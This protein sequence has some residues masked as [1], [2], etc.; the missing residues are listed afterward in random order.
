MRFTF[1]P[2]TAKIPDDNR[3]KMIYNLLNQLCQRYPGNELFSLDEKGYLII[4]NAEND[5]LCRQISA[6]MKQYANQTVYFGISPRLK[7]YSV[8]K[9]GLKQA[10]D[11]LN[12][13]VFYEQTEP[14][15]F[16]MLTSAGFP[17]IT[18]CL[19]QKLYISLSSGNTEKS[20]ELISRFLLWLKS[21]LFFSSLCYSYLEEILNIYVRVA[22]EQN[23]SIYQM[24]DGEA[25]IF[26]RIRQTHTLRSCEQVL[27]GFTRKFTEFIREKRSGER[28]EILKIKEYLQLHYSENIDLNLIAELVNITPSHLSNLFKKETGVNFSTYLTDVRMQAARKLL[29]SPEFL[30]YEVAEKT[31]YS[32]AG[33]FGKAFKKYW[34]ISPEEFKKEQR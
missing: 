18:S 4:Q 20:C 31:G 34:G 21:G 11:T 25:D 3:R 22:R 14:L 19:A 28:S 5:F 1:E 23:F 17:F 24:Q 15:T 7:D 30:I 6:A 8:F 32:N 9:D 12:T 33:Y 27:S 16:R 26:S 10:E 2:E 13:C 29:Q